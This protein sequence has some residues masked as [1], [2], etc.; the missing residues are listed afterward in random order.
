MKVKDLIAELIKMPMDAE[1]AI[2]IDDDINHENYQ[3]ITN[4]KKLDG[5]MGQF[6]VINSEWGNPAGVQQRMV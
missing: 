3:S 1:I 4:V 2:D 6:V 5:I